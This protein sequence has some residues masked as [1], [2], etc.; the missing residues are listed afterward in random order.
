MSG[1]WSGGNIS[2]QGDYVTSVVDTLDFVFT[3]GSGNCLTRDTME[4]IVNPL[5]VINLST[6]LCLPSS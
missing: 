4:L 2:P 5:P 1:V 3:Y 6:R